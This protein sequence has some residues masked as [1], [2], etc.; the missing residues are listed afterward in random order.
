[1]I[2]RWIDS[3]LLYYKIH[4]S[5]RKQVYSRILRREWEQPKVTLPD[6]GTFEIETTFLALLNH[7]SPLQRTVFLLWEVFKFTIG[8]TA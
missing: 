5:R 2:G 6:Q 7:F 4:Q 8:E 3:F 1:M